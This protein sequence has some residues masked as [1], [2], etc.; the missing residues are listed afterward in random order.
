MK[1]LLLAFLL[2]FAA[3]SAHAQTAVGLMP[4]PHPQFFGQNGQPLAGCKIYTYITGTS[5]P[6]GTF[7]DANGTIPNPNPVTCDAGGFVSIWLIVGDTYRISVFDQFGVQQYIIDGIVGIGGGSLNL[8]S[9]PNTWTALQTFTAGISISG[10][11]TF[12]GTIAGSPSFLGTPGFVTFSVSNSTVIANLNAQLW[13]GTSVT[14]AGGALTTGFV[15][16]ISGG[17]AATWGNLPSIAGVATLSQLPNAGVSTIGSSSC[18]LGST[19]TLFN[20]TVVYNTAS[21][22]T[23]ANIGA[24]TMITAPSNG[25]YMMTFYFQISAVGTSCSGVSGTTV[26]PNTIFQDPAAAAPFTMTQVTQTLAQANGVV[27][28]AESTGVNMAQTF[29]AKSGTVIQYSVNFVVGSACAPA[30]KYVVTP[31]LI[32]LANS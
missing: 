25:T 31:Y 6:L 17:A 14:P 10:A 18:T 2:C 12:S 28:Q 4:I 16:I 21:A 1:K 29:R 23:N 3:L 11:S 19:C 26:Q 32:Q 15:P 22:S 20:P 7:N 8:F 5:T 24:T 30:P 9:T 27:G 13:N